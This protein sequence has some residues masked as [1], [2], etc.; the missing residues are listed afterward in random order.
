[1][2]RIQLDITRINANKFMVGD[3]VMTYLEL[4]EWFKNMAASD[5]DEE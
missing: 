3:K 1:M 4:V 5:G 2:K